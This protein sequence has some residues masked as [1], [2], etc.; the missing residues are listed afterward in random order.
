M[1]RLKMLL[2]ENASVRL[3]GLPRAYGDSPAVGAVDG[4]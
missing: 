1:E 2:G 3:N 4:S